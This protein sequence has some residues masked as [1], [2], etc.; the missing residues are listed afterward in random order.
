MKNIAATLRGVIEE[1]KT[2]LQPVSEE[3]LSVIPAPGKWSGKQLIGHL[4]DSAQ[5][6]IRRLIVGQYNSNEVITYRQ[7]DW[8]RISGYQ[9]WKKEDL[10]DLWFLVNHHLASV[11]ENM[12]PGMEERTSNSPDPHTLRWL[13]EDYI[14]HL[15]HHMQE[16]LHLEP[17][18][19]P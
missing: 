11:L 6:N 15:R 10:V 5:N 19:Y 17:V 9:Q 18:P 4:V 16:V 3:S 2:A 14:I 12:E 1:Y 13:A 8:V 7:E